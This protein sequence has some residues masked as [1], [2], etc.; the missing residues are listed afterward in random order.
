MPL[1][2]CRL[3][4]KRKNTRGLLYNVFYRILQATS[5]SST[6]IWAISL[7]RWQLRLLYRAAPLR[8]NSRYLA[9]NK[10]D[11]PIWGVSRPA[12]HR[13]AEL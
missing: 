9:V 6:T 4:C 10:V 13:P 3:I 12:V 2:W 1:K 11:T 7:K 8:W 5:G